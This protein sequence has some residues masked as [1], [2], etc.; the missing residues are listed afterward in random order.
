MNS[1]IEATCAVCDATYRYDPYTDGRECPTCGGPSE[2]EREV[3]V[4]EQ[5]T[6]RSET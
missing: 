2:T 4:T 1:I 3:G 5:L 6:E